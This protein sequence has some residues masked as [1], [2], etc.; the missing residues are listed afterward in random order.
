MK[1]SAEYSTITICAYFN[2]PSEVKA[3]EAMQYCA[4]RTIAKPVLFVENE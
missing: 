2:H 1:D 4:I 3:L